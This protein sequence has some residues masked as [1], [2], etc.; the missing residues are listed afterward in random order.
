MPGQLKRIGLLAAEIKRRYNLPAKNWVT[1][2]KEW[3]R[4]H[5]A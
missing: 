5:L 3:M 1:G 4:D 2:L